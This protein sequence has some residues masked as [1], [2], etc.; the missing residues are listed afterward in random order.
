MPSIIFCGD[1]NTEPNSE[2][3]KFVE[4]LK[5]LEDAYKNVPVTTYKIRNNV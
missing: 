3:I 2:S 1:F 5:F 4:N